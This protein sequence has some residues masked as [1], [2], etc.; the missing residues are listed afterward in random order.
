MNLVIIAN[1]ELEDHPRLRELWRTADLRV[2]ADG[3]AVNAR[4]HLD[5]AP[6][7]VIGDFDSLDDA[8]RAWCSNAKFIQHP[9]DKDETDL[10]LALDL[11][12]TR[13][14]TT[15]TILGASGGRFDQT[16][17]NVMLLA[18]LASTRIHAKIAGAQFTCWVAWERADLAGHIGDTVSLIPLTPR[19]EHV[20]TQGL[21]YPL[22]DETLLLGY[23]RG[24]SNQLA[25]EN[26]TVQFSAG[27]LL[28]AHLFAE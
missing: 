8:T 3:G 2:A 26:A 18:K 25:S 19:V 28:V 12:Q 23:A 22:R 11:A 6:H 4:R 16:L 17:A 21:V 15:I 13:G 24:V 27:L 14:A 5:L 20:V 7:I 1:G 10:E 9:R